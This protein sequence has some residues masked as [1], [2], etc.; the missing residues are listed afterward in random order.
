MQRNASPGRR[1]N[2]DGAQPDRFGVGDG[3]GEMKMK[4]PGRASPFGEVRPGG[5]VSGYENERVGRCQ[6]SEPAADSS[7]DDSLDGPTEPR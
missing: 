7:A 1:R 5:F 2:G 4:P 6:P 3:L